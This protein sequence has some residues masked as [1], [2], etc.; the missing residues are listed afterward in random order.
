MTEFANINGYS[1]LA[2]ALREFP[3]KVEKKMLRSALNKGAIIVREEAKT[4]LASNG[5]VKSGKL[6]MGLKTTTRAT[7]KGIVTAKVRATGEHAYLDRWIEYGTAAHKIAA[8]AAKTLASGQGWFR[9]M[10]QHPGSR[11]KPFLRPA[12][13]RSAPAVLVAV[14]DHLRSR[15]MAEGV[16]IQD[17]PEVIES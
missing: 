15:L 3:D 1:A 4:Q 17:D 11:P 8:K 5:S 13:E 9:D 2:R 12:I 6:R 7:S 14:G 10:V 16:A